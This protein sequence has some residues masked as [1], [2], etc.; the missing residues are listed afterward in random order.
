MVVVVS[1]VCEFIKAFLAGIGL[2]WEP[3]NRLAPVDPYRSPGR[4]ICGLKEIHY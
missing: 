1:I 2:V 3:I 4:A